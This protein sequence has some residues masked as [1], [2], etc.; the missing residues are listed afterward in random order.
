MLNITRRK[1]LQSSIVS[2]AALGF[3]GFSSRLERFTVQGTQVFTDDL[4]LYGNLSPTASSNTGEVFLA[5]P[6][7]FQYNVI[8]RAGSPMANGQPTPVSHDGMG[9]FTASNLPSSWVLVRNHE[10]QGLAG[11]AGA[12]SGTTP[13]DALA[14]GGTTTLIIDRQTRLITD[15]FTSL[16]GTLTNCSGGTTPWRTWISCEETTV[17]V[18]NGFARPH[19]YCFEVVP[20]TPSTPVAL[21]EMGRFRHEAVAV[22]K[23][24][25]IVYL[26]EDNNPCGFYRFI[27]NRRAELSFG[28]R[29]QML[30]IAAQP[31]YDAR[32]NQTAGRKLLATWV[33]IPDP[34]PATAEAN[35]LAVFNQ[36]LA[37]SGATF[38]RLEGCFAVLNNIYFTSTNGGNAGRGQIWKY[39]SRKK[40]QFGWLTL[41]YESPAANVLDFPDNICFGP[42][43][44]LFLCEDGSVD[45]YMRVLTMNGMLSDFAK[46]IVPG[47]E[48]TEFTGGVFSPDF[49]TLFVNIQA[50][51]ITLAIWGNW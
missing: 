9:V 34:N 51:G 25:G 24:T 39:E 43:G 40:S 10:F 17:G 37:Q 28:G 7:G 16:S 32:T 42:Q 12:V 29:L 20:R 21:T 35:P 19:G 18:S 22:D 1:F 2:G 47:L 27:P 36:G 13:Y 49:Q 15:S 6:P 41:V 46:N 48:A 4:P 26:T 31:G 23:T 33:D 50:A 14:G 30:A 11:A 3:A 45:N 44:N 38:T 5:L 8:G